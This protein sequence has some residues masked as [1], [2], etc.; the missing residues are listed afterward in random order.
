MLEHQPLSVFIASDT[1]P[2]LPSKVARATLPQE[3]DLVR[4]IQNVKNHHRSWDANTPACEWRGTVCDAQNVVEI[5]WKLSDL[6]GELNWKYLP[7]ELQILSLHTN[8]LSGEVPFD[9]LPSTMLHLCLFF[10]KFMGTPNFLFLPPRLSYLSISMNQFDGQ[11]N[12][13]SLPTTLN[14]LYVRDNEGLSG[15][16]P[17]ESMSR[18]GFS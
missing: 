14:Y 5:G 15:T 2:L 17:I 11:A 4:L 16:L 13:S 7:Q 12:F 8:A 1:L 18:V 6:H 9:Q 3:Y 10:N